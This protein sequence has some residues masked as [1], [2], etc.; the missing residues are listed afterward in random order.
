MSEV[1][2]LSRLYI[3]PTVAIVIAASRE[4]GR[5]VGTED[6]ITKNVEVEIQRDALYPSSG[7][8]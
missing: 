7:V 6:T 3:A 1:G 4:A 8:R 5:G 2:L